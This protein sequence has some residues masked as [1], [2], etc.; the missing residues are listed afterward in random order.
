MEKSI[1][2][3]FGSRGLNR[4][5]YCKS[6]NTK[7]NHGKRFVIGLGFKLT[8]WDRNIFFKNQVTKKLKKNIYKIKLF[9]L[10]NSSAWR[11]IPLGKKFP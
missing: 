3:Y 9:T 8:S 11:C 1:V 7:A 4:C 2:E 10:Y 6:D 5:G